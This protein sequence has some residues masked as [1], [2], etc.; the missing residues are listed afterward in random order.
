MSAPHL[1]PSYP[2]H[3]LLTLS[4]SMPSFPSLPP[5]YSYQS[6]PSI[7]CLSLAYSLRICALF[8]LP[9][10]CLLSPHLCPL[11]PPYPMLTLS[12]CMPSFPSPIDSLHICALLPIYPLLTLPTSVPPF[13]YLVLTLLAYSICVLHPLCVSCLLSPHLCPPSP[14]SCLLS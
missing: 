1:C 6:V 12:T 4:R 14:I 2:P 3:P 5:A 11:S 13:P 9:I 7:P 10:P 8:P